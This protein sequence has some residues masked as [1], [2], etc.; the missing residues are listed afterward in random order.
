MVFDRNRVTG[1]GV[2]A[3]IDFGLALVGKLR[4]EEYARSTQLLAEY[5]ARPPYRAGTPDEAG[6]ETTRVLSDMFVDFRAQA[7]ALLRQG[8]RP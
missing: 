4:G 7:T 2:T 8:E 6:A 5:D 3:C 1:A